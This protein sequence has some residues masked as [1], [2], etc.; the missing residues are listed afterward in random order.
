MADYS[1]PSCSHA[2]SVP[3]WLK[4]EIK[5]PKC[6]AKAVSAAPGT[7]TAPQPIATR[8]DSKDRPTTAGPSA[9]TPPIATAPAARPEVPRASLD[10]PTIAA[11][12]TTSQ[13]TAP[14]APFGKWLLGRN[15]IAIFG[16]L[17][18]LGCLIGA[19]LGEI[20]WQGT[21][22]PPPAPTPDAVCLLIDCSDSMG[23]NDG[24]AI[25]DRNQPRKLNEVKRAAKLFGPQLSR[26]SDKAQPG[27]KPTS[28]TNTSETDL[29][30][31]RIAVVS[32]G[33]LANTARHLTGDLSMVESAIDGISLAGGTNM[34]DGLRTALEEIQESK[35]IRTIVLFTDG[36]PTV[37]AGGLTNVVSSDEERLR[38]EARAKSDTLATAEDCR[39]KGVRIIAIATGDADVAFLKEV[40]G[41]NARRDEDARKKEDVATNQPDLAGLVIPTTDGDFAKSFEKA[42]QEIRPP[43]IGS[44]AT[45]DSQS[46]TLLRVGI[47][48]ALLALGL[49]LAL[50][51]G[52]NLYVGR[53]ILSATE[54][55][56]GALGGIAAGFVAG[57]AG[58]LLFVPFGESPTLQDAGRIIGWAVLGALV[59]RGM[60]F[61]VPNLAPRRA[62][63]GGAAGGAIGA[64]CFL[65][66]AGPLGDTFGRLLGA[67]I[68]GAAIGL[69]VAIIESAFR[70]AWL[71]ISYGPKEIVTVNLGDLP[72][73]IGS[74]S[75]AC[76]VFA[77]G[78]P[79]IAVR[80]SIAG[81]EIQCEEVAAERTLTVRPGD[82][83][84]VG[85]VTV[86]VCAAK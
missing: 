43:M 48:T 80:Y 53:T 22:V 79:A 13:P 51:A 44:Q 24:T 39:K 50:I 36:Q 29:K 72:V 31:N 20:Y 46:R 3:D 25:I 10:A 37:P 26:L 61:F 78:A 8:S 23:M 65:A 41:V 6:A 86:T 60:A 63:A 59:G 18:A 30:N 47:W 35:L 17:G 27:A 66:F 38:L 16:I 57:A 74:D 12:T 84:K 85:N 71:E 40:A 82:Q 21:Y 15:K 55:S 77:M 54:G 33:T 75:K 11:T 62:L 64:I 81:A 73:A 42:A 67:A 14:T 5:C 68:L 56:K 49:S 1:C 69:L 7:S 32:F 58:Q 28:E 70:K 45:A 83:R 2:F 9:P 19:I 34:S 52:Q 4:A 76:A